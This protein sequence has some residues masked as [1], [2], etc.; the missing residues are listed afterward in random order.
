MTPERHQKLCEDLRKIV[1]E[2]EKETGFEVT[3]MQIGRNGV[4]DSPPRE[5]LWV[6]APV[7]SR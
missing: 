2:F 5:I 1:Q 7:T 6:Y 3:L 4:T